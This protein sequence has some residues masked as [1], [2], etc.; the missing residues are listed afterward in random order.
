MFIIPKLSKDSQMMFRWDSKIIKKTQ[1]NNKI[2]SYKDFPGKKRQN[3][4]RRR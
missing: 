1:N 2:S 4:K 3:Q